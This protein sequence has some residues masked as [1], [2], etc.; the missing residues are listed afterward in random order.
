M[1]RKFSNSV[2]ALAL[3]WCFPMGV[4]A[5]LATSDSEL[6]QGVQAY[7]EARYQEAVQHFQR[8]ASLDPQNKVAHLYMA[9]SYAQQYI[10]GVDTPEN[11]QMGQC[12]DCT[13]SECP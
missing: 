3:F 8:A 1:R 6:Q 11:V 7:K 9:T 10:P 12:R 13:V 5:Q 4:C 2:V